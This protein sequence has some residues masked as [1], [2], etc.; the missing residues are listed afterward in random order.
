MLYTC[1]VVFGALSSLNKSYR[2]AEEERAGCFNCDVVAY[3]LC[4]FRAV[5]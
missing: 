3:V 2:L 1:F 4:L 5:L